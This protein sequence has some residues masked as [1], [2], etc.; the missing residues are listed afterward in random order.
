[1]PEFVR[2]YHHEA[3]NAV[4]DRNRQIVRPLF[5]DHGEVARGAKPDNNKWVRGSAVATALVVGRAFVAVAAVC[6]PNVKLRNPW[7]SSETDNFP[8]QLIWYIGCVL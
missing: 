5:R 7:R 3:F 4:G 1:M 8:N 6:Y 2:N